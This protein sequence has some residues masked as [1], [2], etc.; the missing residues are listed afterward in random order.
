[1]CYTQCEKRLRISL[2]NPILGKLQSVHILWLLNND[3]KPFSLHPCHDELALCS[4]NVL[5]YVKN[6]ACGCA[7]N[8]LTGTALLS[9]GDVMQTLLTS[10]P[11]TLGILRCWCIKV[12]EFG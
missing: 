4:T 12:G 11:E 10:C 3:S 5:T 7:G 1:M 8:A 2:L 9:V 6:H